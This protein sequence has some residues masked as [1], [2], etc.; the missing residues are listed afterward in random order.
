MQI[1]CHFLQEE[2]EQLEHG[3][4]IKETMEDEE[5]VNN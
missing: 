5:V 4:P 1:L 2:D 3:D